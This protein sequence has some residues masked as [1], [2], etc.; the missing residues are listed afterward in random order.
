MALEADETAARLHAEFPR[1]LRDGQVVAYYQPEVEL[2]TGR[3]VAAELLARWEH[4]ELGLLQPARFTSVAEELGLM[5]EFSLVMLRQALV[6]HRNWADA[7]WVVPVSVNIGP[8]CVSDPGFPGAVAQ[9]MREEQVPGPMLT[10][11]V[12]EETGTAAASTRFFAELAEFGVQVSLDDF[13]TGYASLESLGGWPINELKLDRS[14]VRPIIS[15]ASFRTIVR[16]TIDLA[17]QLGVKVVAEGVESAA[18]GSELR[19]LGC[20]IG[21]GFFLGRPMTAAGFTEWLRDPVRSVLRLAPLGYPRARPAASQPDSG[22]LAGGIASPVVRGLRRAVEPVGG[23]ALTV[24]LVVLA[25]YGLWQVFRWGGHQHQAAIGDLAFVPVNGTAV[26]L[27]WRVSRRNDLS[28]ESRRPWRWLSAAI[29]LYMLGDLLQ[30]VYEVILHERAYPT[31]ADAA[32]LS[33]YVVAAYSLL[34]TRGQRRSVSERARRLLD[35]GTVFVGGAVLIWYVALGPALAWGAHFDLVDLVTY[36]YPAGDL[37]LLFGVL[38]AL[39][40]GVPPSAVLSLRIFAVG[41][42]LFIAADVAYDYITVH[43]TYLGGDPVDTLWMV[44][45]TAISLSAACRLRAEPTGF[46]EP[47]RAAVPARPLS[48]PYLAIVIS[49]LLLAVVGLHSVKFDPLGGLLVGAL[50]LTFL[51]STRQYLALRD[52]GK[53]AARYQELATVDGGTGVFNR[54]H[55]MEAAEAAFAHAQRTGKPFAALMVDVDKFKQI[56]DAYG[57]SAGDRVLADLAQLCREHTRPDDIVGRYGGDEFILMVPGITTLRAIQ[58]AD[59]LIRP[60]GRALGPDGNP[61]AY[62]VSVG[63][64]EFPPDGDLSVLLMHADLA[65][66]EAKQAGGGCWRIFGDGAGAEAAQ[67]RPAIAR[68]VL[69]D[70]T[71]AR[72]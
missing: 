31:W 37:L 38:S 63:I 47:P 26:L 32:Y 35:M 50:A 6:Q 72:H 45:L 41:V 65:M 66:Y 71:Q 21:Q 46:P 61:L 62:S 9:L 39:W 40:R 13:G 2:S 30:F 48:L 29:A 27:S 23:G 20:D 19:A 3:L 57:H 1:A 60:S 49:Y 18:I 28:W 8:S 55:F 67:P 12:S 34:S 51:V 10:L 25:G 70:G 11:E 68:D 64:A 36:A 15:S 5:R 56:N 42:L 33:F 59:Q 16:T 58:L 44:A 52:Y 69:P 24:A 7:G 14:I 53:L 22:A 17:H 43:S 4:P 54:R